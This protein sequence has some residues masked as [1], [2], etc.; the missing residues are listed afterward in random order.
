[1][2]SGTRM[3]AEAEADLPPTPEELPGL[4]KDVGHEWVMFCH[5]RMRVREFDAAEGDEASSVERNG[6][7]EVYLLHARNLLE[8]L[9]RQG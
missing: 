4:A 1:M 5:A 3:P 8:G 2:G 9:T 6:W 7:V